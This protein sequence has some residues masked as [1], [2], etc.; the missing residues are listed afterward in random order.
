MVLTTACDKRAECEYCFYNVE[1]ARVTRD[2]LD[3]A[4]ITVLLKKM[5]L[6]NITNL[7]LTGGEPLLREDLEYIIHNATQL[8]INTFLLSNGRSLDTPRVRRLESA[9]LG[10]FVLSL[11]DL[12]IVDRKT[13]SLVNRFKKTSVS[14]IYVM[15]KLNYGR[16]PDVIELARALRTGLVLQPAYIPENKKRLRKRLSLSG[17]SEF[18]WSEL[19]SEMRDWATQLGYDDY[20]DLIYDHFHERGLAPQDCGMGTD[21]FVIDADA[22]VYPCFHHL[23][24]PCGDVRSDDFAQILENV[25]SHAAALRGAA[26]FGEHC[27]SLHT[28]FRK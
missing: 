23:D 21:S 16:V 12:S 25:G 13:V 4:L 11:N 17:L 5:R 24:K 27:I 8:G 10:V 15:T 28:K 20:L 22:R 18:E 9:G 2:R 3:T 19:Y 26:C 1:P 14:Y 6:W 7:Y